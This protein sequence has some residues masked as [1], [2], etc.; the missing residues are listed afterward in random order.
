MRGARVPP[1]AGAPHTPPTI[2]AWANAGRV[3]SLLYAA[4]APTFVLTGLS[5]IFLPALTMRAVLGSATPAAARALWQA[6]GGAVAGT[7][8]M[9]ALNLRSAA[10]ENRMTSLTHMLE[11]LVLAGVGAAHVALLARDGEAR[12]LGWAGYPAAMMWAA[13]GTLAAVGL[14]IVHAGE[15]APVARREE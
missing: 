6:L 12:L 14:P 2:Q 15:G 3:Q 4:A 1:G 5:Y 10:R 11:N 8:P 13:V 7:L 9:V